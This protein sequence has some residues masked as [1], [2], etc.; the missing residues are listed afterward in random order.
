[1]TGIA[2][3]RRAIT[4]A[5]DWRRC[6]LGLIQEDISGNDIS[7]GYRRFTTPTLPD[8]GAFNYSLVHEKEIQFLGCN[9]SIGLV[10]INIRDHV[11]QNYFNGLALQLGSGLW[12]TF[13]T[14]VAT[15]SN[16]AL[17]GSGIQV[18]NWSWFST[19][20]D[21]NHM[22]VDSSDP[23]GSIRAIKILG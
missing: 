8:A 9:R 21:A 13:Q 23:V 3:A 5:D 15:F 19:P 7:V 6:T 10:N 17:V 2:C 11:A 1:M 20:S 18:S 14:A 12:V 22:W 4:V 16:S